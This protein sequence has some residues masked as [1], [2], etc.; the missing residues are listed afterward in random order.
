[1]ASAVDLVRAYLH[2]NGYFTVTEYPVLEQLGGGAG[3]MMTDLDVLA[4]RFAGAGRGVPRAD[5]PERGPPIALQ[6]PDPML[7]RP[8]DGSDMIVG[9]IKE[10]RAELNRGVRD[11]R[12]LAAALIRFGCCAPGEARR[13]VQR[14]R[15]R[16]EADTAHGHRVRLLAF[17]SEV[18]VGAPSGCM[19]ISLGHI[20][21]FLEDHL[22]ANWSV[23]RHAQI[24][25]PA[26]G[27]LSLLIKARGRGK[28]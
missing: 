6:T 28:S 1:M 18:P 11:P 3:R 12:V 17:G 14:L 27:F 22:Q 13:V 8:L 10:G 19:A 21:S 26:L 16:G 9:E 5:S 20:V 7:G 25:D 4:F 24:L 15:Q 2:V 23:V